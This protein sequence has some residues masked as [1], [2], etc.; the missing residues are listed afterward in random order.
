MPEILNQNDCGNTEDQNIDATT[1]IV[2]KIT[3]RSGVA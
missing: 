3:L 2:L 1:K